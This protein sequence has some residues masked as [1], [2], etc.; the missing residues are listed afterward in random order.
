M[1]YDLKLNVRQAN[2]KKSSN[3]KAANSYGY[4]VVVSV[5]IY[6]MH[7]EKHEPKQ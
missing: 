4:D 6:F 5:T 1:N 3:K 7:L 2:E